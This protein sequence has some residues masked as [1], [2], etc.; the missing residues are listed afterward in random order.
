MSE[1]K[2]Q[3][4]AGAIEFS[5]EGNQELLAKQLDKVLEKIPELLKNGFPPST[6]FNNVTDNGSTNNYS[7]NISSLSI[8][9]IAGKLNCK[10]GSDLVIA[11]AA[12]LHF[13]E[14]KK[15]FSRDDINQTMKKA[16]GYYKNSHQANLTTTLAGLEK[17]NTFTKSSNAYALNIDKVNE[18][19]AILSK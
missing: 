2:I 5:G 9:N 16:T 19:N 12:Y 11:A 8:I 13:V 10:S 15:T 7:S 4:K 3:I 6:N 18:L 17:N 14:N 1:S